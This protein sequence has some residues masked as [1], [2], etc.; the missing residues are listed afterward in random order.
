M[1]FFAKARPVCTD[2]LPESTSAS[3]TFF[4]KA[5]ELQGR[6]PR[7]HESET[8]RTV[9]VSI[10]MCVIG[11]GVCGESRVGRRLSR[12]TAKSTCKVKRGGTVLT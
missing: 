4:A 8:F 10:I 3:M 5:R 2:G 12:A 6:T 11:I 1:T 7:K 9:C